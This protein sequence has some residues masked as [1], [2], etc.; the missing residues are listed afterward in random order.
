MATPLPPCPCGLT[1]A[2]ATHLC[3]NEEGI[4]KAQDVNRNPCN[5]RL[6]DHPTETQPQ[7][8]GK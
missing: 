3:K 5:M 4:C 1:R 7:Q 6:A 2:E 8:T